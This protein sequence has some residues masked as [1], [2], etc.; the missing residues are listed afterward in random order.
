M[1]EAQKFAG[2]LRLTHLEELSAHR[3]EAEGAS[4]VI[5]LKKLIHVEKVRNTAKKHGWYLKDKGKGMVDHTLTP[6][7]EVTEITAIMFFLLVPA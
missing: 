5:E 2:I 4:A 6:T 7:F 3:G 1:H